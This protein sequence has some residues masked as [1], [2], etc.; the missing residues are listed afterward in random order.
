MRNFISSQE[1]ERLKSQHR[2]ERDKRVC[3]R[4]KAILLYDEGWTYEQIA[5]A[6]LLTHETIRQHIL[7]YSGSQK[8]KPQSG[9]SI[10]DL[11][12]EQSKQLEEHLQEYT[13]LYV[14]DIIIYVRSTYK[15]SYTVSGMR[16]HSRIHLFCDN[17]S[18][19]KNKAVVAYLEK[20]RIKMHFLPPYS[21]NLNPIE[22]LWKWMKERVMYNTYY[23]S[24][25]S[26]KLAI[27]G[28][29]NFVASLDGESVFKKDFVNRVTDKFRPLNASMKS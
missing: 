19:Y 4:I 14:K 25:E 1:R 21:P 17:A 5:H 10:E 16:M 13:Y 12:P 6:L 7:D 11:A 27:F 24:F 23:E 20:S 8:I 29:L 9:G 18:Y 28:F 3:D 15:V 26:F 22:R 2:R